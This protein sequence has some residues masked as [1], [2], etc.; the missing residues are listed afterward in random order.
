MREK[1]IRACA[2]KQELEQKLKKSTEAQIV[3]ICSLNVLVPLSLFEKIIDNS[4][5][6]F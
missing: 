4:L 1:E 2:V 5:N 6:H 3:A